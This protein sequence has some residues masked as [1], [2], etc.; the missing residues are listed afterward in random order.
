MSNVE[1][2][3]ENLIAVGLFSLVHR[4]SETRVRKSPRDEEADNIQAVRN[5]AN[6]YALL[7][8]DD[9]IAP[10]VSTGPG[11]GH[12]DLKWAVNGTLE[13][14]IKTK[15]D[16]VTDAFRLRTARWIIKAVQLIHTRGIIHS[17]LCLRQFLV[18]EDDLARFS[19][20]AAS[21]Y[22]GHDALRVEMRA[23]TCPEILNSPTAS[24]P[25]YLPFEAH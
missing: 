19:D 6:I 20:F 7:R 12:V 15:K 3:N 16:L 14:Y 22:K 23:T 17:D 24:N 2:S 10:C 9:H 25:M 8:D 21:S 5:E 1:L 11:M 18:Y 4:I 13:D